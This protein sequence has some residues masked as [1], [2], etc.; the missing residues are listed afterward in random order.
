MEVTDSTEEVTG[1]TA[2]ATGSTAATAQQ[3][4]QQLR[5][6]REA[7]GWGLDTVAAQLRMQ[8]GLIGA[9]EQGDWSRLG[10]SVF[11]RG[12]LRSYAR[13]LGI[14]L[15]ALN[16]IAAPAPVAI[17]PM[18]HSKRGQQI[19]GRLGTRLVYVVITALIGVPVWITAQRYL[20][21][22]DKTLAVALDIPEV[23]PVLPL[24][25]PE[26]Q[27]PLPT[28][29]AVALETPEVQP[30]LPVPLPEEEH[31]PLPTPLAV[32]LE[33]PEAQPVL[34][35][36]LPEEHDPLPASAGQIADAPAPPAP[37]P[38]PSVITAAPP[39]LTAMASMLPS[40]LPEPAPSADIILDVNE[41]SWI[42]LYAPDG[43]SLEQ[44]I[45]AAG[46]VRRFAHGQLGR[47]VIGN[48]DGV[49]LRIGDEVQDLSRVRS[50]NVARFAVSSDGSIR[51]LSD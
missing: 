48:A 14:E 51:P 46:E 32:A 25:L 22:P 4:G 47:A 37:L 34:P 35:V 28:P 1:S 16:E 38:A 13:L 27:N 9:L 3:M 7:A 50:A 5:L 30:L 18:V 44:N 49:N 23:Q 45:I 24:P 29:L 36:P 2:K 17:T 40:P 31:D 8:K 12:H 41:D 19:F 43:G 33:T 21:L 20:A 42:E 26:E 15:D 6:A 11:V 39:P 10:A